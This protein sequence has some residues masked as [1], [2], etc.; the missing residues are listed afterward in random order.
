MQSLMIHAATSS[1]NSPTP[2]L[3]VAVVCYGDCFYYEY[4][5]AREFFEAL[6]KCSMFFDLETRI[7]SQGQENQGI[8]RRRTMSTPHNQIPQ[9][10]PRGICSAFHR[11]GAEI[12]GKS[13]LQ[14]EKLD[15][16][17]IQHRIHH[18]N[19]PGNIGPHHVIAR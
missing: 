19:K 2:E 10:D 7:F 6:S 18:L 3:I 16:T 5:N 11:A 17:L 4:N 12:A 8:V 1:K 15:E 14:I 13:R 9:I